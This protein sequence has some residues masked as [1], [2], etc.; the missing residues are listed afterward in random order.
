MKF[1]VRVRVVVESEDYLEAEDE[2]FYIIQDAL[3]DNYGD[4]DVTF[5]ITDVL[6]A[7]EGME[8]E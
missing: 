4:D 3:R 7:S 5:E 8:I 1:I 6:E 2:I